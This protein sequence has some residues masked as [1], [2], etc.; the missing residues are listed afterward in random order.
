MANVDVSRSHP[1]LK[2]N[3]WQLSPV[4]PLLNSDSFQHIP[5]PNFEKNQ[6]EVPQ[7]EGTLKWLVS[8]G[9]SIYKPMISSYPSFRKAPIFASPR[10]TQVT[11]YSCAQDFFERS[12]QELQR[13]ARSRSAGARRKNA[14]K[15]GLALENPDAFR[16]TGGGSGGSGGLRIDWGSRMI[17]W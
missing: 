5:R 15:S 1:S 11:K 13:T 16:G 4:N 6:L 2:T 12:V 3:L 7:N 9:K 10:P 8:S 17:I 14:A